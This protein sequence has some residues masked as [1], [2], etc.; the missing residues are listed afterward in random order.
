MTILIWLVFLAYP[1]FSGW[2][3]AVL[4]SKKGTDAYDWDEHIIFVGER[5]SYGATVVFCFYSG[6]FE[7]ISVGEFWLIV[8]CFILSFPFVHN[9]MYYES[10]KNIDN[11]YLGFYDDSRTSTAPLNISFPIRTGLIILSF[12]ILIAY[13]IIQ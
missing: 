13:E 11:S 12:L 5:L 3:D 1:F 9:G 4:W 6:M 8:V 7:M 2:K 10:R